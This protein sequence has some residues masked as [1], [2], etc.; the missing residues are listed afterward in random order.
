VAGVVTLVLAGALPAA[1]SAQ[2][3]TTAA[4]PLVFNGVTV[5][6]VE[7]GKLVP[8]QRVVIAGNRIQ[9]MGNVSAVKLPQGA[10]VVDASG[11][12]LVPG[13]WDMHQHSKGAKG[14]YSRLVANGVTGIR[15]M[16]SAW[17]QGF[18]S[19][20]EQRREIANGTL[21]GPRIVATSYDFYSPI[22]KREGVRGAVAGLIGL[23]PADSNGCVAL[24]SNTVRTPDEIRRMV[25]TLKA[26]GVDF[27]K[28]HAVS[29]R[30]V[31]LA[32]LAQ[33][34]RV[35]IPAVGHLGG[36]D[37]VALTE[38]EASDSG[39]RSVEHI[40][41]MQCW[42]TEEDSGTPLP[43]SLAK[44]RCA[45]VAQRFIRNQTW[46]TPTLRM[47]YNRADTAGA[48]YKR[49]VGM[50]HR[51]GVPMLAGSDASD[52]GLESALHQELGLLVE[53]GLTPWQALQT[54]T[55]N[56]AKFFGAT[57]SLGTVAPGKLAD[58]VLLDADPL[59]DI[60]N[61]TTI[62]A[63]VANGRYFDRAALDALLATAQQEP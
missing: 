38:G 30:N 43:D 33:A 49:A 6:D 31:Y 56:P 44:Q 27:V 46:L 58:V 35:G 21:V 28:A 5:V 42:Q 14:V 8:N 17:P 48:D 7:Q 18:D 51:M 53:A 59:A 10:Q 23:M 19:L 34:R 62:R 2:Q 45:D 36:G 61:T 1:A 50:L 12:Y 54:A 20:R 60:T 13:L 22:C 25:N 40:N 11:K 26:G 24:N 39:L 15:E 63:V 52:F 37:G 29:D 9:T 41:E 4:A 47:F 3:A 16:S 55:W 32:M 57:D